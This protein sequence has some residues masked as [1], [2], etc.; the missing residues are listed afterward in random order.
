[1]LPNNASRVVLLALGLIASPCGAQRATSGVQLKLLE[2]ASK[3]P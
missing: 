3:K 1:M 2:A